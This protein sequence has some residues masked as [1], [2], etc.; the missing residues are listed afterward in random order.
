MD[1]LLE[2]DGVVMQIDLPFLIGL[3]IVTLISKSTSGDP[4]QEQWRLGFISGAVAFQLFLGI[5]LPDP[6]KYLWFNIFPPKKEE[7]KE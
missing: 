6:A 5:I 4:N 1:L 7:H 3:I 2:I